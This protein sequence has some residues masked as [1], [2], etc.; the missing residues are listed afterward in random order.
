MTLEDKTKLCAVKLSVMRSNYVP[1]NL[2]Y[3]RNVCDGHAEDNCPHGMYRPVP[4]G[5]VL[6]YGVNAIALNRIGEK[7]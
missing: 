5:T 2:L 4:N 3:C 7:Q 6:N 1:D